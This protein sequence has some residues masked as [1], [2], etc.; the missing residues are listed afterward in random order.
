[1]QN[2]CKTLHDFSAKMR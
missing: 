2:G 1:M